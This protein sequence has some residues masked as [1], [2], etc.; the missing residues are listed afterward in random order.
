MRC[1]M[2]LQ[3]ATSTGAKEA[4]PVLCRW[5]RSTGGD[6][7]FGV[8]Q[9]ALRGMLQRLRKHGLLGRTAWMHYHLGSQVG[10]KP[11]THTS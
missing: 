6:S 5:G 9:S 10:K 2:H 8:Q 11:D 4:P 1:C 7:K 3:V